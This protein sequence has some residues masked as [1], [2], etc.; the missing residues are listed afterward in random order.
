MRAWR[1]HV[2]FARMG[3]PPQR[4]FERIAVQRF[5]N[6]AKLRAQIHLA[7]AHA[8]VRNAYAHATLR[9]RAH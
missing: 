9:N 7:A 5:P 4:G 6:A 8:C 3:V 1:A 2:R